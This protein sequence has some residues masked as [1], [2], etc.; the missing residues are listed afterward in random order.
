MIVASL[1]DPNTSVVYGSTCIDWLTDW[2]CPSHSRDMNTLHMPT[3]ACARVRA[4][5][6]NSAVCSGDSYKTEN[7]D[8]GKAKRTVRLEQERDHQTSSY[9]RFLSVSPSLAFTYVSFF[10]RSLCINPF[11]HFCIK[12]NTYTQ[13]SRQDLHT[14][15]AYGRA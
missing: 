13:H 11:S 8:N 4:W 9:L 5:P 2:P 6:V 7:T 15:N 1:S 12:R 10:R 3:L 14:C